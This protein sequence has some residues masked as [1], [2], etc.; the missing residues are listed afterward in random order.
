MELNELQ[1]NQV[2]WGSHGSVVRG[3]LFRC[4]G[5]EYSYNYI[6]P[7]TRD[8]S[9]RSKMGD[10]EYIHPTYE[11]LQWFEHCEREGKFIPF[12]SFTPPTIDLS[13]Q[14]YPLII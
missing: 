4:G 3:W 1:R 9:R 14:L 13:I 10:G 5:T 2:Y 6:N 7:K 11:E 8:F 12:E